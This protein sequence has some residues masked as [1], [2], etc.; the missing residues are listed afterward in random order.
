MLKKIHYR[1][2]TL[3]PHIQYLIQLKQ[4]IIYI[5]G[6][7]SSITQNSCIIHFHNHKTVMEDS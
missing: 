5:Q 2:N 7:T 3:E 6:V 1:C 4:L